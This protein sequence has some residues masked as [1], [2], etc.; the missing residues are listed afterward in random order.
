MTD[1]LD[2]SGLH[3][4]FDT[5]RGAV[6]AVEDVDL[7]IEA[8][9]TVGLVGESG[10][11]KSVTA[12]SAMGLIDDPGYVADGTVTFQDPDLAAEF[13]DRYADAQQ[14]VDLSDG[15]IDLTAAPETAMRDVRGGEMSMIFQDPMTSLNPA[16]TVGEQVAESLRLHRYG[17]KRSDNWFNA[18]REVLPKLGDDMDRQVA[19]D[20]VEILREVGIPE[21][22][23]RLSEYP[24]EFSGGMRQRVLI[25]IA[26]ASRP[27]LLI[28]DE[29]TTA[30][31]V[32]I[33][34]QILDLIGDLQDEL[35][36]S[37]LFITHD[38][39]VIA[40][41]ADRVAVMYAGN[42]VEEGPVEEI[43]ANPSHPYTYALLESIPRDER[44][45]LTPIEGNVPDLIDMP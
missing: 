42:I 32:T 16:V 17:K 41:V 7:S 33:Q 24:H 6:R 26:L 14:F 11:G 39:G 9:E 10:S 45:R 38:L 19:D 21:A 23:D 34:A 27:Q 36:M 8:G 44:D 31:D 12:L 22:T 2:I 37:V 13:D 20:T 43:F 4:R 29:P 15:T 5:D 3:T 28:A 18:I 30:L 40:E 25:A 1:L 35:G